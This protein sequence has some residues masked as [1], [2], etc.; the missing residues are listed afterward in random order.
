MA[1]AKMGRLW[2]PYARPSSPTKNQRI[3]AGFA[4]EGK[5]HR[6]SPIILNKLAIFLN[7]SA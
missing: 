7:F 3:G 5:N 1:Q 2:P 4:Q 6:L